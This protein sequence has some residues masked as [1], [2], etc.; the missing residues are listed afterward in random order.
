[1][2]SW[3][4][5]QKISTY[6]RIVAV[7]RRRQVHAPRTEC[8]AGI[9]RGTAAVGLGGCVRD[10]GMSR[11]PRVCGCHISATSTEALA[12]STGRLDISQVHHL[13]QQTNVR[14]GRFDARIRRE[15]SLPSPKTN[16]GSHASGPVAAEIVLQHRRP[17][18]AR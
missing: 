14:R 8:R 1:M 9:R 7:S 4:K 12:G 13:I 18:R 17:E 3:P 6:R 16:G 11:A 2:N 5:G 10:D 15:A